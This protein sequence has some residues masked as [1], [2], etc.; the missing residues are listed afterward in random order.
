MQSI[1]DASLL[2]QLNWRYAT[3]RFDPSRKISETDWKTLAEVLRLSPSSYGLMPWKG[4]LIT[5]LQMRK[6]LRAASWNQPQVEEASHFI[7]F[8][9]LKTVSEEYVKDF[10]GR[11]A[12]T[13][14]MAV[15]QLSQYQGMILGDVVHGPRSNAIHAWTQRQAYIAMGFLLEAAALKGIDACPMEGLDPTKYDEILNISNTPYATVAAVALGYRSKE[16][17][18][19]HLK[20]VRDEISE[21]IEVLE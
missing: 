10:I 7:V 13:R 12:K 21:L 6:E 15:E 16:D 17:G 18:Y 4:V 8:K 1:T 2:A 19:Q 3:K 11:A 20:K 14:D 5:N 9:T